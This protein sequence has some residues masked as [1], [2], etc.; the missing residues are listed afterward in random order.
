MRGHRETIDHLRREAREIFAAGVAAAD[1]D[2]AVR[3]SLRIGTMGR[4][5]LA[6]HQLGAGEELRIVA[7]GKAAVT[8]AGAAAELLSPEVFPGPGVVVVNRENWREVERFT[9]YPA[10]HPIPD[11]LGLAASRAVRQYLAEAGSTKPLLVL[12][13]G[14]GSALLPS[15]AP[16]VTLED[17]SRTTRLLLECGADIE[18]LNTVRKHLS[19][20]KGGG[21]ARLSAPAPVESLILSDVIG[22]DLSTIAS[23]CTVPDPTTFEDVARI[24]DSYGLRSEVPASVRRRIERGRAGEICETPKPGDPAFSGVVNRLVGSNR[25]SLEA[26]RRRAAEL[27]YSVIV[28]SEALCGDARQAARALAEAARKRQ[29]AGGGTAILAGGETTVTV[30]G[31]GKG[32]RN[33]ELALAFALE[34]ETGAQAD[35]WVFLSGGT[36]GRDGPTDVAGGLVDSGTIGRIHS[37]G[38]DPVAELTDN[39][40]FVALAAA[41]DQLVTGPTGTNVA[42]LQIFL[43]RNR[44][45]TNRAQP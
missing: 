38:L 8:M 14:G 22:D 41:G 37:A 3:E 21:L 28:A 24:L 40:S 20:L 31:R 25:V 39:N 16:P 15:P 36:D 45:Q 19:L 27:G 5:I 30:T 9:V 26:A 12:I 44:S 42:D 11:E 43:A 6:E 34:L 23:G 13:S 10:G 29:R 2:R 32:G 7:F 18:E 35:S 17:K 4:P 33:Q 1:P